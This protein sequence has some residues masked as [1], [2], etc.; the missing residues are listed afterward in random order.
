MSQPAPMVPAE[1]TADVIVVG[2]GPAGSS[3]A[4]HLAL[5]GLDVLLLEKAH[6][7]RVKICADALTPRAVRELVRLGVPTSEADGWVKN[8]GVRLI[9]GGMRLQLD[10]PDS[11]EFPPFGLVR[12]GHD[13]AEMLARHA[14]SKGAQ[15]RQGV[16]VTAA[17]KD[18]AGRVIGVEADEIAAD[19]QPTGQKLSF[20]APLV[21]AADGGA[22]ALAPA[23][24][25]AARAHRPNA[26][27]LQ[28]NYRSPRHDDD[29][30]EAWLDLSTTNT[31]GRST[32]L[33]GY[34]WIFGLDNGT[35][36]VGLTVL[37]PEGTD[38]MQYHDVMQRW[39]ATM[40]ADW[41]F[42][43]QTQTA[44][45][46][47]AALPT[48]FDRRPLYADGLL[49]VGDAAAAV[50]PWSGDGIAAALETGRLAAEVIT[51]SKARVGDA[52]RERVLQSYPAVVG[53]SLGG[54]YTMGRLFAKMIDNPDV[55]RLGVKYALPRQTMMRFVLKAVANLGGTHSR[56][57][58]DRALAML[59]RLTPAA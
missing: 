9:G 33:P 47:G 14:E 35:S 17:V 27:A 44:P 39:I 42:S 3:V 45:V 55:M 30:L 48:G 29:Y 58:D 20:T 4:A 43:E 1:A 11:A 59:A 41:T 40:P 21:V 28:A 52:G 57:A 46:Q 26:V 19:G 34:G 8:N 10:W 25:Q 6:F 50:N 24:T 15:L 5:A 13:L 54:Y 37:R 18:A 12:S 32:L 2:A 53:D 16:A 31:R 22:S 36:N 56:D 38:A 23:T 51:Q 49:L 7:P